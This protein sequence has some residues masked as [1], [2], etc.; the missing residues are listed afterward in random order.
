MLG[1]GDRVAEAEGNHV[2]DCCALNG[3]MEPSL[4]RCIKV[5]EEGIAQRLKVT[6]LAKPQ[7][8]AV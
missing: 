6:I 2:C 8:L 3:E 7:R 1:R 4:D 5:R